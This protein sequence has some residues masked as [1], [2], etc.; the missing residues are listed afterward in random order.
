MPRPDNSHH[1]VE[2]AR[3]RSAESRARVRSAI[4]AL[5]AGGDR[6]TFAAVAL[7]AQVARQW[8]YEQPDLRR[9][10]EELR[11]AQS[12]R[13]EALPVQLRASEKSLHARLRGALE[14]NARLRERVTELEQ[15]LAL[16]HGESR[17][18]AIRGGRR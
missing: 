16:A 17:V 9:E 4:I 2:A 7:R 11:A 18:A 12:D 15:E 8:L 10:I 14:E 3:R 5:N 13:D 1:L 6:I